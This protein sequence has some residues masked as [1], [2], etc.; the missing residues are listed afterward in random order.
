MAYKSILTFMDDGPGSDQRLNAAIAV[1]RQFDAHLTVIAYG[2]DP[3]VPHYAYV[4]APGGAIADLMA[5]AKQSATEQAAKVDGIL[6]HEGVRGEVVAQ[7]CTY[8][9]MEARF[10]EHAQYADL[11]VLGQTY[12]DDV[13]ETAAD[14]L[15]GALFDGDAAVLVC[16]AEME[17]IE[18][19]TILVAWNES[20]EALHSVRRA[21]PM[22]QQASE[23][24]ILIIDAADSVS[25]PGQDL[26]TMLARHDVSNEVY[27]HPQSPGSVSE[28]LRQR[29]RE[30]GARMVV[31][32]GYGHSRFREYV[33]GGVT[34][35]ILSDVPVPVFMTH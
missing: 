4:D 17:R 13:Q 27:L 9:M 24:E 14:A 12:G 15:A 8:A 7:V 33:I 1:A 3:S 16:P 2:Y 26:A 19:D 18:L 34:R 6:Q 25:D 20:R 11:V 10:G 32:G 22:L 28:K 35:D 29:I 21:I 23:V 5:Q 31:M 30:R